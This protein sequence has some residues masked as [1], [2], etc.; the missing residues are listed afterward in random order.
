MCSEPCKFALSLLRPWKRVPCAADQA[1][2]ESKRAP[3]SPRLSSA[4][5]ENVL[6]DKVVEANRWPRVFDLATGLEQVLG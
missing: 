2:Y 1:A 6:A 5:V 3:I 4:W